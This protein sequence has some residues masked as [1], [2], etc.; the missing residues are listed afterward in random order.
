MAARDAVSELSC[1]AVTLVAKGHHARALEKWR[2]ALALA[3]ARTPPP[4]SDCLIVAALRLDILHCSTLCCESANVARAVKHEALREGLTELVP[5]IVATLR[6]RRD[7]DKLL[8]GRC[9]AAEEAW[10]RDQRNA[11]AR[12]YRASFFFSAMDRMGGASAA[13]WAMK[14]T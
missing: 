10:Q 3:L 1:T 14:A 8:G 9:R 13:F 11:V 12:F 6:R 2:A 4:P 5:A 7:A